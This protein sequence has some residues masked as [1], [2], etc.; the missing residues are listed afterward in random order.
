MA[1][2]WLA[3]AMGGSTLLNIGSS[4]FGGEAGEDAADARAASKRR[5]AEQALARLTRESRIAAEKKIGRASC[6]ERV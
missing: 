5:Q 4:I 6:R 1:V 2:P 3:L